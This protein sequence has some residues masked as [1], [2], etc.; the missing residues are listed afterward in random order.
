[1]KV[2]IYLLITI[3]NMYII[4][5]SSIG[6]SNSNSNIDTLVKLNK[7]KVALTR[8]SNDN[9]RTHLSRDMTCLDIPCISF[10]LGPDIH[11]LNSALSLYNVVVITSPQVILTSN[12]III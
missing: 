1:M 11:L 6:I 7:I 10:G 2:P 3:L 9:L 5:M 12:C 4:N 8:E